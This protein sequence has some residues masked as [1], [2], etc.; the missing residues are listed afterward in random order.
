MITVK[1]DPATEK[2][3]RGL[4]GADRRL[5]M[6]ATRLMAFVAKRVVEDVTKR[7]DGKVLDY[8]KLIVVR[9]GQP[10]EM[11]VAILLPLEP[12]KPTAA[13]MD[14]LLVYPQST[15]SDPMVDVLVAH[16]PWPASQIPN[17]IPADAPVTFIGRR[18]DPSEVKARSGEMMTPGL[19]ALMKSR[20]MKRTESRKDFPWEFQE[21]AIWIA[22]R[23]E[24]GIDTESIP[25]WRPAIK[26]AESHVTAK[27]LDGLATY[28]I[29]G[30]QKALRRS[31]R[32]V[33][34]REDM[35]DEK[36][37]DFQKKLGLL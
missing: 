4:K 35:D 21:D 10:R 2:L 7:A 20:G 31:Y 26:A 13:D 17:G 12:T 16:G 18:V 32:S 19:L 25:H 5:R 14:S 1:F 23:A 34:K 33:L 27:L 29:T 37:V 3:V 11:Q 6:G 15:A 30:D 9:V 8:S 28:M 22:I 36:V 24:Y